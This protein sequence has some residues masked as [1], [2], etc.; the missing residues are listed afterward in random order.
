MNIKKLLVGSAAG[1]LMLGATIVPAFAD[2]PTQTD[3]SGIETAWENSSC[4]TIQ[5]GTLIGSDG[6]TLT[7]GFNSW[8]YNYQA[9][10]FNGTY[11]DSYR[12]AAWCQAYADVELVMKWNDAWL[13]NVD[14]GGDGMDTT[15]DGLL[16]R[17]QGFETY[18]GSGAWLTNHM[19]GTND[20]GTHWDYFVKIVAAPADAN[21][22]D[23]FWYTADGLE[24]GPAIWGSFAV[25]QEVSN[26]PYTGDHGLIYNGEAPTGFG[27]YQP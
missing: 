15:R 11:C 14:C 1:A 21:L 4:T 6:V 23:G 16:D 12:N 13:S 25:I 24:I 5:S 17:Y 3:S 10:M 7:T 22:V 20:D 19:M 18:K 26:D 9:H 27:F 2:K 8:G